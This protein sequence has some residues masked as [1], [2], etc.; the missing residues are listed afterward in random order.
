MQKKIPSLINQRYISYIY[1]KKTEIKAGMKRKIKIRQK[2]LDIISTDFH[3]CY[4]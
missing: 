1:M 2:L 4:Y 3:F